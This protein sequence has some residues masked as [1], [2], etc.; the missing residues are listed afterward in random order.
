MAVR[1]NK[2][3]TYTVDTYDIDN[4]RI[5]KTFKRRSDADDCEA[6]YRDDR[7]EQKL[8]QEKLKSADVPFVPALDDIM[9]TKLNL[10][11]K[12]VGK[13]RQFINQFKGFINEQDL[14]YVS[15]FTPD[16]ATLLVQTITQPRTIGERTFVP[17]PKTVNAFIALIKSFFNDEVMK[18]H[19]VKSP[20]LH[21]R[22][23]KV[24]K[25]KP[26]FYTEAEITLFF[27]QEMDEPTRLAFQGLLHTGMR[28]EELANVHWS[29]VDLEKRLIKV[30]RKPGFN[31]KTA[32]SERAIPLTRP[33]YNAL[34]KIKQT[35]TYVFTSPEGK[36]IKERRLLNVCKSIAA[37]AGITSRAFL[38]KFRHTYA[39]HL[40]MN[41]V[42]L[43][44]V[45][46]LLGHSSI[47]ETLIYAHLI[48]DDMH[49][50]VSVLNKFR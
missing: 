37:S 26:E 30:S 4:N 42:P 27:G 21:I 41:R 36:Q 10:R 34:K 3:G 33:L 48:P 35:G 20:M 12:T 19:I 38:H 24:E 46:K 45:Q 39:T 50:D 47:T 25:V 31:P 44:R 43:E 22:N 16:H 8:V 28:I 1:K 15:E 40:V 23:L 7:R 17:K 29:D 6:K 18:G 2:Y 13:Y 49:D 14:E 11:N 32:N 5:T 9:N